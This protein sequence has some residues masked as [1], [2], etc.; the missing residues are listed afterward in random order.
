[1]AAQVRSAGVAQAALSSG[2]RRAMSP[3]NIR[4]SFAT[5]ADFA[6]PVLT[7]SRAKGNAV[8]QAYYMTTRELANVTDPAPGFADMALSRD[9]A[10]T[11]LYV[12]GPVNALGKIRDGED[13]DTALMRSERAMLGA[14]KR[15]ILN[16]ARGTILDATRR[17]KRSGRWQRVGDGSTCAFCQMLIDRGAVY[18]E[19]SGDFQA[20]DHCGCS[21]EPL[22]G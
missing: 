2:Y 5:F 7:A 20:H 3:A 22:F 16:G 4:G 21:A 15:L 10:Y 18:S 9:Q 14:A 13:P 6:L 8:A 12:T 11:S 19:D 17:D 1:M